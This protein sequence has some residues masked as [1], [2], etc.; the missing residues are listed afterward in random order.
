MAA[1]TLPCI[2]PA[3]IEHIFAL[4]M[5]FEIGRQGPRQ[6]TIFAVQ[7]DRHGLPASCRGRAA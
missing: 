3:V 7:Q 1:R 2:G 6:R 5:A 4:A